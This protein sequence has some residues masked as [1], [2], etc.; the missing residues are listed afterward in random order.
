MY[1]L[2]CSRKAL[3]YNKANIR[4]ERRNR[5]KCKAIRGFNTLISMMGKYIMKRKKKKN[6]GK[7]WQAEY[8]RSND[9][10]DT[11]RKTSTHLFKHTFSRAGQCIM[12]VLTN[13]SRL[14]FVKSGFWAQ[15]YETVSKKGCV[16][17]RAHTWS[18]KGGLDNCR[19]TMALKDIVLS[20]ISQ[21]Q[22]T[23]YYL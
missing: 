23:W 3:G 12:Q 21:T 5:V 19:K 1:I 13:L 20:E 6:K 10:T 16:S 14:K 2:I 9:L 11:S 8:H 15:W 17:V 18:N 7:T 4:T 22:D